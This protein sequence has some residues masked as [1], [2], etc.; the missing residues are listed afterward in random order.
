MLLLDAIRRVVK[1]SASIAMSA[2]IVDAKSELAQGFAMVF[3]RLLARRG[4]FSSRL[5]PVR[6]SHLN[7]L[8]LS[9]CARGGPNKAIL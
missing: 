4:V 5:K 7:K 2:I 8:P 9:E 1:A 6:S 3:A